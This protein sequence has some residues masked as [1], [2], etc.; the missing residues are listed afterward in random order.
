[1]DGVNMATLIADPLQA[2]ATREGMFETRRAIRAGRAVS[3]EVHVNRHHD[4]FVD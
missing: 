3:D 1:M 4:K 2:W